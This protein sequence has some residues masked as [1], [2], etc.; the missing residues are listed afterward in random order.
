MNAP[1]LLKRSKIEEEQDR[2][3]HRAEGVDVL[4]RV[5]RQPAGALGRVVTEGE[6]HRAMG[7]LVQDHRRH[8]S[9]EEHQVEGTD[10]VHADQHDQQ[11]HPGD[12]PDGGALVH[13]LAT[14]R[15]RRGGVSPGVGH[16]VGPIS[17]SRRS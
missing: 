16:R 15:S 6:G 14:G 2:E 13:T 17:V 10:L 11:R 12:D 1:W 7:D 9:A 3:D 8:Q 4:D 5:E